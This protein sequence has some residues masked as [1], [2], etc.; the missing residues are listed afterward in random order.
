MKREDIK[1]PVSPIT[2][3]QRW[4]LPLKKRKENLVGM[5]SK[6]MYKYMDRLVDSIC[7]CLT[8]QYWL[9]QAVL[10]KLT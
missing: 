6:V 1:G 10:I 3:L 4:T 2:I 7:P 8:L 9:A 5:T